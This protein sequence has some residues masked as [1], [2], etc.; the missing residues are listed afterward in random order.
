SD[1]EENER[2]PHPNF[3]RDVKSEALD[4]ENMFVDRVEPLEL[5]SDSIVAQSSNIR[6]GL[7]VGRLKYQRNQETKNP[8][9]L[10]KPFRSIPP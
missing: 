6:A 9:D 8:S 2:W 4:G 7:S 3:M 5:D 10:E 1:V